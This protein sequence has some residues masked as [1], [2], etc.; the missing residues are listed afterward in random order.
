MKLVSIKQIV[1]WSLFWA[2]VFLLGTNLSMAQQ[3]LQAGDSKDVTGVAAVFVK[4]WNVHDMDALANLFASDAEFIN[5]VGMWWHSRDAI[6]QAHVYSHQTIF[7][8]SVL[9]ADSTT[10]KFITPDIAIAYMT[11][12]LTGHLTPD[13]KPGPPRHGILSLVM[14][15]EGKYWLV[16]SAQN[17]DIVPDVI[18]IPQ[19]QKDS[20]K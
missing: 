8:T 11:W 20:K 9:A 16:Q 15:H 18:T 7:K 5:V 3:P 10:V 4:A 19:E 1:K 17:T 2:A 13:G 12:T 6:R 14:K